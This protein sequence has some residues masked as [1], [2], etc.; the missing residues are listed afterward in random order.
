MRIEEK[1]VKLKIMFAD[2]GKTF[3]SKQLDDEGNPTVKTNVVNLGNGAKEEDFIEVDEKKY[4]VES[5]E[6]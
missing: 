5:E 2:E 4:I 3:I 1:Q 6:I